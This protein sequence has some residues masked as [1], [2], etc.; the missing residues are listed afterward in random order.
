MPYTA[1][2]SGRWNLYRSSRSSQASLSSLRSAPV[3]QG[4]ALRISQVRPVASEAAVLATRPAPAAL[5]QNEDSMEEHTVASPHEPIEP[6]EAKVARI[7]KY[8]LERAQTM[9]EAITRFSAQIAVHSLALRALAQAL[10]S[11]EAV[12]RCFRA[13]LDTLLAHFDDGPLTGPAQDAL[14][15]ETNGFLEA[16]QRQGRRA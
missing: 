5:Q 9:D 4:E 6:L 13:D 8:L 14:L 15:L 3:K 16:L 7:T 11:P 12:E 2:E 10:A 1:A